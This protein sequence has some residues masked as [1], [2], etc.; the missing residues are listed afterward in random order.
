MEK[1]KSTCLTPKRGAF[2]IPENVLAD[3]TPY[4]PKETDKSALRGDRPSSGSDS[5]EEFSKKPNC[6]SGDKG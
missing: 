5:P 2:P 1:E 4:K 3:A 6:G